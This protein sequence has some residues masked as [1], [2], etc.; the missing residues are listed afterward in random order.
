MM[1]YFWPADYQERASVSSCVCVSPGLCGE[2]KK[3]QINHSIHTS[4]CLLSSFPIFHTLIIE[5][6]FNASLYYSHLHRN[7]A[8]I[9]LLPANQAIDGQLLRGDSRNSNVTDAELDAEI[10]AR[11][12][13]RQERRMARKAAKSCPRVEPTFRGLGCRGK[14]NRK[15][16][17]LQ[18][19]TGN[20]SLPS[21][22]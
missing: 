19:G 4:S 22:Q 16:H 1:L 5:P 10:A 21:P 9:L 3:K 14:S 8:D 13:K 18:N 11:E 12:S 2:G 17:R 7:A 6:F 15:K 20:P